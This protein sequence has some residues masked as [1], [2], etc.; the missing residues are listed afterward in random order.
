[1]NEIVTF[2]IADS[3]QAFIDDNCGRF[4]I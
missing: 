4:G 1:M 3:I 2:L